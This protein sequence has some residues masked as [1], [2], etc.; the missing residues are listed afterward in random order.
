MSDD[1]VT[2]IDASVA[3]LW[4]LNE[5]GRE[6]AVELLSQ[7]RDG[8]LDLIAPDLVVSE[9]ANVLWK[10][11]RSR[12][13]TGE[14]SHTAAD[15]LILNCPILYDSMQLA[16]LALKLANDLDRTV[17]DCLYLALALQHNATLVTADTRFANA[18]KQTYKN[19]QLIR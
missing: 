17:Y 19:I 14:Q 15:F 8:R 1:V 9:T 10:K 6:A 11:V 5:P 3:V 7:Y 12:E 2:V 18:V 4:V 13:L 16:R